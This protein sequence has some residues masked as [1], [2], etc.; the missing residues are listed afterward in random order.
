[1]WSADSFAFEMAITPLTTGQSANAFASYTDANNWVSVQVEATTIALEKRVAGTTYSA[2]FSYTHTADTTLRL[3]AFFDTTNGS[4]IR[5]ADYG[6]D[7]T[8]AAFGTQADTASSVLASSV[9][10]GTENALSHF[11]GDYIS[12]IPYASKEAAQW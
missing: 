3:Q 5:V 11:E 1:V 12:V 2:S 9:E 8:A 7:I 6:S 10:I 4:G